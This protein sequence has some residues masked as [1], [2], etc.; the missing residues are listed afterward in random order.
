MS[1]TPT[2]ANSL[3]DVRHTRASS[4]WLGTAIAVLVLLLLVVFL[5][6]NSQRVAVHYLGFSGHFPLAVALLVS[7]VAGALV[8]LLAGGARVAQLRL[9]SRRH[10]REDDA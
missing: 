9:A 6:Q 4:L 5:G 1:S 10:L 2:S 3:T 7:A 8:V